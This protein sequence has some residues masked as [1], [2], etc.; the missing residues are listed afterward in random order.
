MSKLNAESRTAILVAASVLFCLLIGLVALDRHILSDLLLERSNE[1][2]S[3]LKNNIATDDGVLALKALNIEGVNGVSVY[4]NRGQLLKR[5]GTAVLESPTNAQSPKLIE[6][7]LIALWKVNAPQ[8]TR[9]VLVA[10][11]ANDIVSK[12]NTFRLIALIAAIV[13]IVVAAFAAKFGMTHT[14]SVPLRKLIQAVREIRHIGANREIK[15]DAPQNGDIEKLSNEFSHLIRVHVASEAEV[16]RQAQELEHLAMHDGLTDLPN[17]TMF[18]RELQRTIMENRS[19]GGGCCV[20]V[21]NLDGFKVFN[22]LFGQ[23][24]GDAVLIEL[25]RRLRNEYQAHLVARTESDNFAI[26]IN[27][28]LNDRR[29][30][31]IGLDMLKLVSERINAR[32]TVVQVTGCCGAAKHPD[33]GLTVDELLSN[34]TYALQEAKQHGNNSMEQFNA[35]M[36]RRIRERVELADDLERALQRGEFVLYYQPKIDL[37]TRRVIGAEALIRWVHP[38]RGMVRPDLFIP[39]VEESGL[40][41]PIGNWIIESTARQIAVWNKVGLRGLQIAVNISAVQFQ[42]PELVETIRKAQKKYLER[43]GQLELEITE[44]A[45]M[46]DPQRTIRL[47]QEMRDTGA[48]LAI[49]DFGTGYSS[50][51]YLKQFPV[52]TL[53]IDQAFVRNVTSDSNDR[54]ISSAVVRLGK[55]F[56]LK[57]VA[58]GIEDEAALQTL[59]KMGCDIGQGFHIARPMP[60]QDFS[61]WL[62]SNKGVLPASELPTVQEKP[63]AANVHSLRRG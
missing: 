14:Q 33:D 31:S 29:L 28:P 27:E 39:A 62:I 53:K 19:R 21:I 42:A 3:L 10:I 34:A 44:S 52:Q 17:R 8:G 58:E 22:D 36:K 47:L 40:I 48:T 30:R 41:V 55:H 20:L 43:P 57:L 18:K 46:H 7:D 49:D 61:R 38:L 59:L 37:R 11:D 45:V 4:D 16:Q 63:N 35:D 6:G 50:L 1:K 12:H 23:R 25:G 26:L 60:A 51:S 5:R 2:S 56:G 54:A 15:I 9:M 32:G 13:I 24:I